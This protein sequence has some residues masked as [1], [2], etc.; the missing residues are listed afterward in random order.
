MLQF[1]RLSIICF[2]IQSIVHRYPKHPQA[3]CCP[4]GDV[5]FRQHIEIMR[6]NNHT[7]N[8]QSLWRDLG[9]TACSSFCIAKCVCIRTS[10]HTLDENRC[11]HSGFFCE[12][13][14]NYCSFR[15]AE[16]ESK[17]IQGQLS[18]VFWFDEFASNVSQYMYTKYVHRCM[19][20]KMSTLYTFSVLYMICALRGAWNCSRGRKCW[21]HS[22]QYCLQT[23]DVSKHQNVASLL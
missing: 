19:C 3:N 17:K 15:M 18:P 5:N 9:A 10:S 1:S 22:D 6:F 23:R 16:L 20:L 8:E 14:W 11:T 13:L 21:C 2:Q 12:I 7:S 4:K